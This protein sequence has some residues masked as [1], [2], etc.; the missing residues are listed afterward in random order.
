M[1]FSSIFGM[2]SAMF[3]LSWASK[4]FNGAG[5][6]IDPCRETRAFMLSGFE[7]PDMLP[8]AAKVMHSGSDTCSLFMFKCSD[9]PDTSAESTMSLYVGSGSSTGF[10]DG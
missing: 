1:P 2:L 4:G 5:W 7:M 8:F 3:G 9:V 10:S 6:V